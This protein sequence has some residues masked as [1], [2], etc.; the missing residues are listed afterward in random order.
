[1]QV[2]E[3]DSKSPLKPIHHRLT[4]Q[5]GEVLLGLLTL[6][7]MH[8]VNAEGQQAQERIQKPKQPYSNL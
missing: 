4:Q 8:C 5:G 2:R 1:M 6:L 3:A 7:T